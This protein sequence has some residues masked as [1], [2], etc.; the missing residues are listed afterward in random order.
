MV[1]DA[2]F[3]QS[4]DALMGDVLLLGKAAVNTVTVGTQDQL[5]RHERFEAG[6][7][8][9]LFEVLEDEIGD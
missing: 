2:H 6:M 3:G 7:D 9:G 4:N 5:L 1:D 8:L